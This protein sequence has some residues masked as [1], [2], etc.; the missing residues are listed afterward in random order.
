MQKVLLPA[1]LFIHIIFT[2]DFFLLSRRISRREL[3]RPGWLVAI[4]SLNCVEGTIGGIIEAKAAS[5][6][7]LK[8]CVKRVV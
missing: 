5:L 1:S 7:G 8:H 2:G 4:L 6:S 3:A